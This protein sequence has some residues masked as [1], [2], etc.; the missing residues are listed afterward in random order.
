MTTKKQVTK[1]KNTLDI[2]KKYHFCASKDTT[3]KVKRQLQNDRKVLQIIYLIRDWYLEYT[4]N[5][6]NSIIRQMT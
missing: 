1:E 3:K 2:I 6:N 5:S 4:K